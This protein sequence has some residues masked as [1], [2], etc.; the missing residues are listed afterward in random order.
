MKRSILVATLLLAAIIFARFGPG[1]NFN[2]AVSAQ[3]VKKAAAAEKV[4]EGD[5]VHLPGV[6]PRPREIF[7]HSDRVNVLGSLGAQGAIAI[8]NNAG[9][10]YPGLDFKPQWWLHPAR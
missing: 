2:K 4:G 10:G 9:N 1:T 7:F 8:V 6:P 3:S 5:A